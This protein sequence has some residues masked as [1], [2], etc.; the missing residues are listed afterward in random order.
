MPC[1]LAWLR[2]GHAAHHALSVQACKDLELD[3]CIVE[4]VHKHW[5][6]KRADLG[7][8]LL[9]RLWFEQPWA[10]Q[11]GTTPVPSCQI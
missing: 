11:I 4:A 2:Q 10:Q 8:P 7:R 3:P 1:C 9:P 5:L 6:A